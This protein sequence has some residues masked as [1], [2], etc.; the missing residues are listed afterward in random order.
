MLL[1]AVLNEHLNNSVRLMKEEEEEEK[2]LEKGGKKENKNKTNLLACSSWLKRNTLPL[3]FLNTAAVN[4]SESLG[5]W[6]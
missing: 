1:S 6:I 3:T 2:K 5:G 4:P